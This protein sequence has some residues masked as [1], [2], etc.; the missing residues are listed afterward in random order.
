MKF[1][2]KRLTDIIH[3]FVKKR[4][5]MVRLIVAVLAVALL[6]VILSGLTLIQLT[7]DFQP[8]GPNV[9]ADPDPVAP[10]YPE[11]NPISNVGSLKTIGIAAYWDAGLTNRVNVIDWGIL[12]PGDQKSFL[13][14]FQN[15]GN[16]NVTLTK[17]TSN[18][19]PSVAS[20]YLFLNW[21]YN[22]Q[23]INAGENL[24]VTLTL[25]VSEG[26]TGITNFGFDIIAVGT[27]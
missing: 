17:S 2:L 1:S 22:G 11:I 3:G 27:G 10:D 21:D 9:V 19:N 23:K 14:Y 16:S 18:W 5:R 12:E 15:E 4:G 20:S 26:I 8:S 6:C 25:S 7:S 24:Q 13:I